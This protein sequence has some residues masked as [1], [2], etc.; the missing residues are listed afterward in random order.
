MQ[1]SIPFSTLLRSGNC[2]C[3]VQRLL[4][5]CLLAILLF[6][7]E[8][9]AQNLVNNPSFEIK[10]KCPIGTSDNDDQLS[11]NCANWFSA[12]AAT[13]DYFNS[14]TQATVCGSAYPYTGSN[15]MIGVP[16]NTFG[17]QNA[18]DDPADPN[19]TQEAYAG[20]IY[21]PA[22]PPHEHSDGDPN[23]REYLEVPLT[24]ALQKDYFYEVSFYVSLADGSSFALK[25]LGAHLSVGAIN[26]STVWG[27]GVLPQ[28]H[29]NT[30]FFTDKDNWV[31]IKGTYKAK[32][33]E[34]HLTIGY[35]RTTLDSTVDYIRVPI[36][37]AD[38]SCYARANGGFDQFAYYYVDNVSV[39]LLC[40]CGESV[41]TAT[42]V[43]DP[44]RPAGDECCYTLNVKRKAGACEVGSI[45][46]HLLPIAVGDV[47]FNQFTQIYAPAGNWLLSTW[48]SN[49]SNA[50][51][52]RKTSVP[53]QVVGTTETA[54]GFCVKSVSVTR[55]VI[56][57]YLDKQSNYMCSDTVELLSCAPDPSNCCDSLKLEIGTAGGTGMY[58]DN[59]C[60]SILSK[61]PGFCDDIKALRITSLTD[62][63]FFL[64][65]DPANTTSSMTFERFSQDGQDV[66]GGSLCL[67][68]A[69]ISS[70][71]VK[72]DY[73]DANGNVVCTLDTTLKCPCC[74]GLRVFK[75]NMCAVVPGDVDPEACC[76]G[77]YITRDDGAD[78]KVYG[79]SIT[80]GS[81]G[82]ALQSTPIELPPS[83]ASGTLLQCYGYYCLEPGETRTVIIELLDSLGSVICSH[84]IVDS[85][86]E[87]SCCD[88]ISLGFEFPFYP[89]WNVPDQCCASIYATQSS[90]STCKVYGVVVEDADGGISYDPN[91]QISFPG[92]GT[93]SRT[94]VASYCLQPGETRTITIK[95][96]D[97]NGNV[98]CTKTIVRSCPAVDSCCDKL[99]AEFVLSSS[100][101]PQPRCCMDIKISKLPGLNCDVYGIRLVGAVGG[102][103]LQTSLIPIPGPNP[104]NPTP[105]LVG[106]VCAA[107]GQSRTVTVEF[108]DISG[109]V[110]CS[111]TISFSCANEPGNPGTGGTQKSGVP[112]GD[113]IGTARLLAM[114][115][116]TAS[117]TSIEY[118]LPESAS[119][120]L[121]VYNSVGQLIAVPE[122]G[123]RTMGEHR[124]TYATDALPSGMYYLKLSIGDKVVT[125]PLVVS[126]K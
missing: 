98:M 26:G 96:L 22:L 60:F 80:N 81:G 104:S 105:L 110:L 75:G 31:Q 32:G 2:R 38:T 20:I 28:V 24:S 117:S 108:L 78:C 69:S 71:K 62:E 59:C 87:R 106:Q 103:A 39:T 33:G 34:T 66:V 19:D 70:F 45:R 79:I 29:D 44:Q 13:P 100:P 91:R 17:Y 86:E 11:P 27:L 52:T 94:I 88:S 84:V 74:V 4:F 67:S 3:K 53:S 51:W 115:N 97:I 37:A 6:S 41:Y 36:D 8:S 9:P 10:I 83:G 119:M 102:I 118:Y 58:A 72:V 123:F 21:S 48:A 42:A 73:L 57:D 43:A 64:W 116:P 93:C 109:E 65:S 63:P 125:L 101:S 76:H 56:I 5:S 85:C 16:Q 14:C 113:E 99:K 46:A 122:Q 7:L 25:D 111:K 54:I 89:P 50:T 68:S 114:P 30:Q 107:Y 121:E 35:F 40:G 12:N 95:F 15:Q 1:P 77:I 90:S 82:V 120:R 112:S 92:C 18:F 55:S 23:R 124:L 49:Y 61:L 47:S 126:K